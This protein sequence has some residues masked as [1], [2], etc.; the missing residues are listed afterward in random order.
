M[1]APN[2]QFKYHEDRYGYWVEMT[3]LTKLSFKDRIRNYLRYLWENFCLDNYCIFLRF[4]KIGAFNEKNWIMCK[5]PNCELIT[6]KLRYCI[7]HRQ[8]MDKKEK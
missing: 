3:G 7:D 8:L 2:D 5:V 4:F 1:S 6:Y